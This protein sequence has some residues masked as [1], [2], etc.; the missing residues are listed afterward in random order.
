MH[1]HN[2]QAPCARTS[3][4]DTAVPRAHMPAPPGERSHSPCAHEMPPAMRRLPACPTPA[5]ARSLANRRQH[6]H[7][8]NEPRARSIH[9]NR[10]RARAATLTSPLRVCAQ[11]RLPGAHTQPYNTSHPSQLRTTPISHTHLL[12]EAPSQ[13]CRICCS[14][15][16]E[17]NTKHAAPLGTATVCARHNPCAVWCGDHD[18]NPSGTHLRDARRATLAHHVCAAAR[19]TASRRAGLSYGNGR[20]SELVPCVAGAAAN[21]MQHPAAITTPKPRGGQHNTTAAT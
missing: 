14:A 13:P 3:M 6:T 15:Y 2:S 10:A 8:G 16:C 20:C 21:T 19:A 4:C 7:D 5:A 11:P 12:A 9:R 17:R 1:A 18:D